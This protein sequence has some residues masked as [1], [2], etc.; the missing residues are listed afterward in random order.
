MKSN[1]PYRRI[2]VEEAFLPPELVQRYLRMIADGSADDPGF[3]SLWGFYGGE[4]G[5]RKTGVLQRIQDL[6]EARIRDMDATGMTCR[7][8]P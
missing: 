8:C 2:A 6:G 7:S 1:I 3:L 4:E 5:A